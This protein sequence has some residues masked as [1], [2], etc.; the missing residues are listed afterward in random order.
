VSG[1]GDGTVRVWDAV[2]GD[3]IDGPLAGHDD[4]V[5]AVAIGRVGDR[6]VIVP[7]SEDRTVIVREH[8]PQPAET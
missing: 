7:G 2:S 1:S 5:W 4:T 6:D 3:P 8:R